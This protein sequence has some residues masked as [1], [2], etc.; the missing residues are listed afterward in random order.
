MSYNGLT[1]WT[2]SDLSTGETPGEDPRVSVWGVKPLRV[3]PRVFANFE[4]DLKTSE[5]L[6]RTLGVL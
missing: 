3:G 1:S 5:T 6:G 4:N 2:E